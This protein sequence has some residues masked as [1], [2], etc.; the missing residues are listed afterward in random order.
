[1][2]GKCVA[3]IYNYLNINEIKMHLL[4]EVEVFKCKV[5]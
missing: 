3:D 1:M 2:A 4:R 5:P